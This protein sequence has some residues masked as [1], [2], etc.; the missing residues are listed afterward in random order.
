ML[1]GMYSRNV[2]NSIRVH[3]KKNTNSYFIFTHEDGDKKSMLHFYR[4]D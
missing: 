4:I 1:H 2:K 3:V